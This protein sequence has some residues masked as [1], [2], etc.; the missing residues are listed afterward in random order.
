MLDFNDVSNNSANNLDAT[1]ESL[2]ADLIA[3]LE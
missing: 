1:R 2:R 3:R